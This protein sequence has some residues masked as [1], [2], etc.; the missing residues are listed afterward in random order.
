MKVNLKSIIV[1]FA[2][3][4]VIATIEVYIKDDNELAY[5]MVNNK[6]YQSYMIEEVEVKSKDLKK[7]GTVKYRCMPFFIP[8]ENFE[9]NYLQYDNE[10]F[11]GLK[12]EEVYVKSNDKYYIFEEDN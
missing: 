9:S 1:I 4:A 8:N 2:I 11:K 7:I 12:D 10:I 6:L 3:I 5:V